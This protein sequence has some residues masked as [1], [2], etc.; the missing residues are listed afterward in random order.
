MTT[1]TTRDF[2]RKHERL[3][4]TIDNDTFEATSAIPGAR[5]VEFANRYTNIGHAEVTDQLNALTSALELVLLPDSHRLFTERLKSLENPIELEQAAD[6]IQWLM[7]VYG[8]RPT[9]PSSH[10]ASTPDSPALGTSSTDVQLPQESIP[11][12]SLPIA[13]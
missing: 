12:N 6:V 13:G 2:T 10:S 1:P 7:E 8:K 9:K 4:F 3:V 11:T 5:L